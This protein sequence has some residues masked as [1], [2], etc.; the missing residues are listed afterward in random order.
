MS[1]DVNKEQTKETSKT[2]STERN[3]W[4]SENPIFKILKMD[5][6]AC[7]DLKVGEKLKNFCLIVCLKSSY[8]KWFEIAEHQEKD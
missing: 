2:H 3:M 1:E 5:L 8:N 7:E 6:I 4:T